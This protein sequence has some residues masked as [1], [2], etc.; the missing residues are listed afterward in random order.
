MAAIVL[1]AIMLGMGESPLGFTPDH[2]PLAGPAGAGPAITRAFDLQLVAQV[3]PG[4]ARLGDAAGRA[5][6][7]D[8]AGLFHL[9][10]T[11]PAGSRSS[12]QS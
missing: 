11:V 1:L 12:G 3:H 9:A 2:L 5:G 6:R 10:G 4:F 7:F 8:R